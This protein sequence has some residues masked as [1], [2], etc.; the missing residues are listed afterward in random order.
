[1]IKDSTNVETNVNNEESFNFDLF[2]NIND[3]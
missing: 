3:P 2:K 1:M